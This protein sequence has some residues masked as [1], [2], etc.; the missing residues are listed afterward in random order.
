MKNFSYIFS[1]MVVFLILLALPGC[2]V[3]EVLMK[4]VDVITKDG[5]NPAHLSKSTELA[6]PENNNGQKL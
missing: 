3:R 6:I 5:N 4:P 2:S 1:I